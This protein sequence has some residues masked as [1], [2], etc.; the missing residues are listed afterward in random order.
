ME[1]A[2]Q[3]TTPATSPAVAQQPAQT[4]WFKQILAKAA[5]TSTDPIDW[6]AAATQATPAAETTN[7]NQPPPVNHLLTPSAELVKVAK[8][9]INMAN[10]ISK[11]QLAAFTPEQ[12]TA[13]LHIADNAAQMGYMAAHQSSTS[14]ANAALD[15]RFAE[16]S[17]QLPD[18]FRQL[19]TQQAVAANP[20][21]ASP[22]LKP[23]VDAETARFRKLYPTATPTEL[24]TVVG[25][26]L[27]DTLNITAPVSTQSAAPKTT[28][29][30]AL[31]ADR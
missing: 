25:A 27:Q 5:G 29:W 26:Y 7:P 28:D 21:L 2:E 23:V 18:Q 13:L 19:Q 17:K 30:D 8:A 10:I 4:N 24:A 1:N 22:T 11:E 31:F 20:I 9:N 6:N 15:A 3:T 14:A 16:Q 12:Q